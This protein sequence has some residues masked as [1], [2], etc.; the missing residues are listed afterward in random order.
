MKLKRRRDTIKTFSKFNIF[1]GSDSLREKSQPKS[2]KEDDDTQTE[3]D[4]RSEEE[5]EDGEVD[6]HKIVES[7]INKNNTS[8]E[9]HLQGDV[10]ERS[11]DKVK[12]EEEPKANNML[13]KVLK[14]YEVISGHITQTVSLISLSP[15]HI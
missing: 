1:N 12:G 3:E 14:S 7:N 8:M 2:S 13:M 15:S 6:W 9:I 5:R 11:E 10:T 4:S